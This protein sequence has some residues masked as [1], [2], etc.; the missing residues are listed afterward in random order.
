MDTAVGPLQPGPDAPS[1]LGLLQTRNGASGGEAS[2]ECRSSISLACQS[3]RVA[4]PRTSGHVQHR[5]AG[6]LLAVLAGT[7]LVSACGSSGT[8]SAPPVEGNKSP[9]QV[10]HDAAAAL[11]SLH[12]FHMSGT[13]TSGSATFRGKASSRC[14]PA[15]PPGSSSATNGPKSPQRRRS[16]SRRG[17]TVLR[18]QRNSQTASTVRLPRPN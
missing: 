9:V 3:E 4:M 12:S 15:P 18:T 8:G 13:I 10:I 16:A 7:T 6:V 14:S 17:W 5:R 1:H 2:C 11:R